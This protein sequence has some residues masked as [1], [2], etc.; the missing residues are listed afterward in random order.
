MPDP[1]AL[2]HIGLQDIGDGIAGLHLDIETDDIPAEV[3]RL[4]T[5]GATELFRHDAWVVMADPA[6]TRFCLLPPESDE[7]A[8]RARVVLG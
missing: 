8:E 2:C 1:A 4:T 3:H 6:G 5:L 7:F